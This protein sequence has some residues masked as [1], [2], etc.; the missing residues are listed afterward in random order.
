MVVATVKAPAYSDT[1]IDPLGSYRYRVT[2]ISTDKLESP[3]ATTAK[4]SSIE[5]LAKPVGVALTIAKDGVV[6]SWELSPDVSGYNVYR[7]ASSGTYPPAPINSSLINVGEFKDMPATERAYYY[8][9]RA[10]M[11]STDGE[12]FVEGAGS[13][14]LTVSPEDFIPLAPTGIDVAATGDKVVVFWNESPES[15]VRGYKVYRAA[16]GNGEFL[17]VGRSVTLAFA[18][19]KPLSGASS[20]RVSAMGPTSEGP[21]SELV[22]IKY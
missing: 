12:L 9:V 19:R 2:A 6:L 18:D 15:W 13:R 7:S 4:I 17:E 3:A 1:D 21:M 11:T 10:A 22:K 5:T 20:Y 14:E 8:T 16:G